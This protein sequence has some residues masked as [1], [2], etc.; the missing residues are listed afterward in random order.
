MCVGELGI[1]R[2]RPAFGLDGLADHLGDAQK[3]SLEAI[4]PA[5]GGP[6]PRGLADFV[7]GRVLERGNGAVDGIARRLAHVHHAACVTFVRG[8]RKRLLAL[9]A[10]DSSV[11][12]SARFRPCVNSKTIL[13]C[14][15][16]MLSICRRP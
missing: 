8:H 4:R 2:K 5:K 1:D 9:D 16:K 10:R 14:S 11:P 13:P 12:W 3:V 7:V 15:A 6:G